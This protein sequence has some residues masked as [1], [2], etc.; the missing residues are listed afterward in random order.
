MLDR[1]AAAA[2]APK[3]DPVTV[4]SSLNLV[5]VRQNPGILSIPRTE[6]IFYAASPRS[7]LAQWSCS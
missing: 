7:E 2:G 3:T 1:L 6:E 5:R 4:P